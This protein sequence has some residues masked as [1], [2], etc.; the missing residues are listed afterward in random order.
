MFDLRV[1]GGKG[2]SG[3][4]S[5]SERLLVEVS[6]LRAVAASSSK[7]Y[8]D[9]GPSSWNTFKV[10]GYRRAK[11]VC[12]RNR[13]EHITEKALLFCLTFTEKLPNSNILC[14]LSASPL[15]RDLKVRRIFVLSV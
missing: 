12:L 9:G 11:W 3:F 10:A 5:H 15:L 13:V 4:S 14:P 2:C 6:M 7:R 1:A 8:N